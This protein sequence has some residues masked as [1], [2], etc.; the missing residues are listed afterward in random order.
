[1]S[2]WLTP[3]EISGKSE[4]TGF[5]LSAQ[6]WQALALVIYRLISDGVSVQDI[7]HAGLVLGRLD[8]SKKAAHWSNCEVMAL[9]S[10]GRLYK[11]AANSTREFR[12]GLADYFY[13]IVSK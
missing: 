9:D 2:S 13:S 4:R 3:L 1:M 7:S 12:N 10:N 5:R 6:I 8:F 11:N